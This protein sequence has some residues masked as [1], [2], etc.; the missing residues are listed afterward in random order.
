MKLIRLKLLLTVLMITLCTV[1][2]AQT[3]TVYYLITRTIP[4]DIQIRIGDRMCKV[5]DTIPDYDTI[6]VEEHQLIEVFAIFPP[7]AVKGSV[8]TVTKNKVRALT[9]SPYSDIR[10]LYSKGEDDIIAI[11]EGD[12]II[13]DHKMDSS[14]Q[15]R[16]RIN[17]GEKILLP[18]LSGKLVLHWD[19]FQHYSG[20]IDVYVDRKKSKFD[21]ERVKKIKIDVINLQTNN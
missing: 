18:P 3:D 1:L 15:Y 2:T 10:G 8:I 16:F 17:E 6:F 13:I 11:V 14:Y 19:L 9:S 4:I 21:I 7:S 12:S 5:Q 20:L